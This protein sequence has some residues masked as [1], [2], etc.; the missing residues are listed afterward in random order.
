LFGI[1]GQTFADGLRTI[2]FAC[3]LDPDIANFHALTPF[4]GTELYDNIDKYGTM[5]TDLR[6]FTYQGAAFTPY[7]MTRQEIAELRRLA[8]KRFYSRPRFLIRR[9]LRL[10][11][12]NDLKAAFYGV[13]SLFWLWLKSDVFKRQA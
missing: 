11:N 10:R 3:E 6:D 5:S 9:F 12:L 4:P 7:T 13:K 8:F 1:P 2:D